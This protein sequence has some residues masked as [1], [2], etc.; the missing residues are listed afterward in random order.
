MIAFDDDGLH[1]FRF[2]GL[3]ANGVASHAVFSRQGGVSVGPFASLN[4]SLSVPDE[5]A[6]V[7]ANRRRAY[8]LFGRDT[9]TVVHAH[10]V[11]GATV[12]RVTT[13]NNGTWVEHVDGL[14][15]DQPGCVLGM[16][17]ADCAPIFLYDPRRHAIGLGHAGWRGT[18]VDL[19][20]AM[21]R[22]MTAHFGSDPADLV[23]AIGP[24][25]GPCCYEV[26]VDVIDAVRA[27]F[28][29]AET[30]LPSAGRAGGRHFDL[31]EANRRNLL[32]A[33]VRAVELSEY[34]TA[35]RTDLFFSHRAERGRTGR[36]GTVFALGQVHRAPSPN[37]VI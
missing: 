16:N 5:R 10:L 8:G 24:C 22:A 14:I 18:V 20:G 19:P 17:Y 12:A 35:C 15:T 29:G 34:C 37:S 26:G 7:Y 23:A 25:I 6:S 11:H 1:Y 30:L 13:A 4:L 31:P 33:G 3:P 9:D 32:N 28:A 21:V 2:A 36:F 27:A